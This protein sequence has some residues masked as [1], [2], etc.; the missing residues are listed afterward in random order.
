MEER[1]RLRAQDV[2]TSPHV[3]YGAVLSLEAA[4]AA[5]KKFQTDC[6]RFPRHEHIAHAQEQLAALDASLEKAHAQSPLHDT[7]A[8]KQVRMDWYSQG[9]MADLS[10]DQGG[11]LSLEDLIHA[12]MFETKLPCWVSLLTRLSQT[13]FSGSVKLQSYLVAFFLLCLQKLLK[14]CRCCMM[15]YM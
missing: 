8:C 14:T 4:I 7:E 6:V 13:C 2:S 15:P 9:T 10:P 1:A 12:C 5:L 11:K 3:P